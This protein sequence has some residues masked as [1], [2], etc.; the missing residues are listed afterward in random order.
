MAL[1]PR[2]FVAL[3]RQILRLHRVK[4]PG[5]LRGMGDAVVRDEFHKHKD[6]APK[7]LPPFYQEWKEYL[8]MMAG[9]ADDLSPTVTGELPPDKLLAMTPEQRL[10]L[11]KIRDS[12]EKLK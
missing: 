9:G 4:L 12:I 10:Q 2:D 11:Q 8:E 3:Y 1:Q 6:A 7:F 5:P